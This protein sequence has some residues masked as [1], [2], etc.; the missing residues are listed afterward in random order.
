MGHRPVP[1]IVHHLI[2]R[3]LPAIVRFPQSIHALSD[4]GTITKPRNWGKLA[5]S[6]QPD[7]DPLWD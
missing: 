4:S 1:V 7:P 2:E 6:F 5:G 3:F